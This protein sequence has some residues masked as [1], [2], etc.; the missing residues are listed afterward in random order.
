VSATAFSADRAG[1]PGRALVSNGRLVL[2]GGE[3]EL[4]EGIDEF[5]L[6]PGSRDGSGVGTSLR[7]RGAAGLCGGIDGG[8]LGHAIPSDVGGVGVSG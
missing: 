7:G 3:D 6:G 1:R 8:F 5:R 4:G 2:D